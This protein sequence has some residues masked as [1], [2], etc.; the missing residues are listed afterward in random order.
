MTL[1]ERIRTA[2]I[3][4]GITSQLKLAEACGWDSA[5][6]IGNYEQDT[7]EPS[8]SD[9]RLIADAVKA[10]G[11]GYAWLVVGPE[12]ISAT[13]TSQV[14]RLD[15]AKL[16]ESIEA[17]RRVAK[18]MGVPY[19]PVTHA[20]ETAYTYELRSAL[21]AAPSTAE[22]IDFGARVAERLRAAGAR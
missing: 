13:S 16:A 20:A 4:A 21:G 1:G 5:S 8:L 2:R 3:A 19:D 22:V 9:L 7:R 15:A 17:L 10:S 6:R 11:Y 18:N 12:E 14:V